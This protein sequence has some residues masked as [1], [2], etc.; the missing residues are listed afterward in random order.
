MSRVSK[1]LEPSSKLDT[2]RASVWMWAA[3]YW[4]FCSIVKTNGKWFSCDL[5]CNVVALSLTPKPHNVV[6]LFCIAAFGCSGS[7]TLSSKA[8]L[9][10]VCHG[11]RAVCGHSLVHGCRLRC[12][13]SRR[14]TF[15]FRVDFLEGTG[16][17]LRKNTPTGKIL[18]ASS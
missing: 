17:L 1:C 13:F 11:K 2:T 18:G 5:P 12:F 10:S 7:T 15:F 16:V 3:S 4:S 8:S 14:R 6:A 9:L